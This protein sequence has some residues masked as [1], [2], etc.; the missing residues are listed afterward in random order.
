MKR[1]S[2][3]IGILLGL[4]F[5][6][7]PGPARMGETNKW[8]GLFGLEAARAECPNCSGTAVELKNTTFYNDDVCTCVGSQSMTVGPG[9]TVES[10][11][12]VTFKAPTVKIVSGNTFQPG[13]VINVLQVQVGSITLTAT[14]NSVAAGATNYSTIKVEVR[15][16]SGQPVPKGT[17]ITLTTTLGTF[18]NGSATSTITM[19]DNTGVTTAFLFVGTTQG[20]VTVTATSG[21][22][23]A[24][25]T[26]T[27]TGPTVEPAS[28]TVTAVPSQLPGNGVDSSEIRATVKDA[29]GN[30]VPDG[31]TV[32]FTILSG[33]GVLSANSATTVSGAATV[34]LTSGSAGTVEV[35][36]STSQGEAS[37]E[38]TVTFTK[39]ADNLSLSTSQ[40]SI[41]TDNSDSATITAT[42]LDVNHVPFSGLTVIFAT[43]GGQIS[44]SSAVTDANGQAAI[45]LSSGTTDRSNQTVTITATVSGLAPATIP[46]QI[47]GSTLTFSTDKTT[48]P[49]DGSTTAKLTVSAR[50]AGGT[51]GVYNALISFTVSGDG[52]ATVTPSSGYTN[53]SG[54]LQAT[55]TGTSAGSVTVTAAGLGT[56]AAQVYTVTGLGAGF[57]IVLPTAEP[58]STSTRSTA[59]ATIGDNTTIAFND[60]GATADTI[61]SSGGFAFSAGDTIMVGG[62][63]NN[64]GVYTLSSTVLPTATTLTLVS[65]DSLTTEAAGS[66]VTITNGVLVRVRAPSPIANVVFATTIGVWDNGLS[67]IKI[68]P[69]PPLEVVSG[70][71]WAVLT[72]N[73]AGSASIQAYDDADPT[74][75]DKTTVVF[76]APSGDAAKITL[77]AST[78]VVPPSIGGTAHTATLTAT[79][80]TRTG[81]VVGGAPVAF[82]IE[83]PTGGG[84]TVSPVIVLT[85]ASGVAKTTF[86]SGILG[87]GAEG[88]TVNAWVVGEGEAISN[89]TI[90]FVD[91]NPDTITRT[92]AGG[93]F[94]ADG[95]EIGEQIRVQGSRKLVGTLY[96]SNDGYYTLSSTV[97][98]TANT[99]TL[100][101]ADSLN[102][103]AAGGNSVTITAVTASVNI[104]IGGT[105]GSVAIGRG[106]TI[107]EQNDA[108]YYIWMSVL[109]SDSNGSPVSGAVVSLSAWPREYSSGVWYDQNPDETDEYV[110]Y[111]TGTFPNED[112]NENMILDP[113]E[114]TDGDGKLTP[115]S[116]AAGNVPLT[117]TTDAAGVAQFKLVYLKASAVWIVDR[118]RASTVVLGTEMS[119]SLEFRLPAEKVEA[120]AGF[121]PDSAYPIGLVTSTA[122]K[123]KPYFFPIFREAATDTFGTT[124]PLSAG[125]S[126]VVSATRE[127]TYDPADGTPAAVGNIVSDWISASDLGGFL[128][129]Y[130]PLRII[131]K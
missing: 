62:S 17:A 22:V 48:I 113:G 85:D 87:S 117:V 72:S 120:E 65:S 90:A 7:V 55:V 115:P 71:V 105:P 9:V 95:F 92:D 5:S 23:T 24:Q 114:D 19:P 127:Y 14:P 98:P 119:S 121:L 35:K 11:A 81:Q 1:F 76:S 38:V 50:D 21:G 109:V 125:S 68:K 52:G 60:N 73:Q 45:V 47:T 58:F 28:V 44:A 37:D 36:A 43:D 70:Y 54:E 32:N 84:E 128:R 131:I 20:T 27:V 79:V 57:E 67:P 66:S 4:L 18:S 107:Y 93:S 129:A 33:L 94:I 82:S 40:T 61:T 77:Q 8:V 106:T 118:I 102:A 41:K 80:R 15:D 3:V 78:Y 49:D 46:I 6:I 69:E 13:A 39:V 2:V 56:A 130:F 51:T 124:S 96:I 53:V 126:T 74:T 25:T 103:L 30:L 122:E 110:P 16:T 111:I 86:T 112:V 99:L 75:T 31:V 91:S 101:E 89:S 116:S 83:N 108:T 34:N 97:A 10:R 42:V 29:N 123:T 64:D 63:T 104:V 26:V 59:A 100:V 12:T 88:V